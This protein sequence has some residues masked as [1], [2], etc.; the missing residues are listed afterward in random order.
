MRIL[1]HLLLAT[2]G[3]GTGLA[4]TPATDLY[5]PS[6]GHARGACPGGVCSQWRTDVWIFNPPSNPGANVTVSFLRR[7]AANTNPDQVT[8]ALAPG[9]V[10][11][12]ADAVLELFGAD[13][14]YGALR[15]VADVPVVVTGRIYDA[16][17]QTAK[18]TGTAGQLFVGLPAT[19]AIGT[20]QSTDLIGLAQDSSAVWRSN[21][22][23]VE[24]AGAPA[25][26][27]VQRLDA[28]GNEI[29]AKTYSVREREAKQ[30][31][32][33]DVVGPAAANQ[34]LRI[35]VTDGAGR[36]LAFGSRIDNTTGDPSTVEMTVGG[37]RD[38][39]Y[40]CKLDKSR[41]DVPVTLTVADGAVTALDA[42]VLVTAEDVPTCSGGELL[43]VAGAL[44]QAVLLDEV[45]NFSFSVSGTA[46]SLAAQLHIT[47][48]VAA[49]GRVT[50]T[51][52]TVLTGAGSCSGTKTWPLVGARL[53]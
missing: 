49:S 15:F 44:P 38:G 32:I 24:T 5:L 30:F 4:A 41:Y 18:G 40:L 53:P 3:V 39:T 19:V 46:G 48:V 7:D 1:A 52:T 25:T 20:G 37:G 13:D 43:A 23:F 16:N 10:Q 33:A 29:A 42:T 28:Q 51:C 27:R 8:L 21:F 2:L 36:I 22:G 34:R 45:G 11:E 12:I 26:V 17:V 47:G 9:E 31:N 6:V 50:G 35:S 14:A